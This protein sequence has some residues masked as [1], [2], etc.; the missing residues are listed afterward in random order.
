MTS[1]IQ[2]PPAFHLLA[3]P[4]GATCNLDCAYCFFLSKEMLYPGS[5]FRMADAMLE[6]YIQQLLEAHQTPQ[7]QVA[8]QGGEPTLMGL[9]FFQR[10]IEL[11]ERY[12]KPGTTV[13]YTIQTNGTLLD[14]DWAAFFKQHNFL[15]GISIDGPRAMHDA[16]RVD[17]GGQPTFD[18]VIRGL[19][20]LQKHGVETNTLTTLHHA[21]ADHPAEV[22][23]F[24]RDEC[25]SRFQQYIPIIERVSEVDVERVETPLRSAQHAPGAMSTAPWT[26][27]R[28]RPLYTQ[29]GELVTNRSVTAEQ[30]GRFLIG[31]FEEWVRRDVGAV[32]VQMFDVALANWVGEPSGLCVHSQ[33]C[34]LALALEH[35]GDLF[36]CDHFVE[37]AY[38][39]G[40]ITE[41]LMIELIASPQQQQFGQDKFDA[42]P[43]YCRECEVRFACHGGC[44]K[45]RFIFTPDGEPGLNYLCAGYKLFFHH[46]DQPMRV[47]AEALRRNRA[48]AEI[49]QRYAAQDR[50]LQELFART[51]RNDPCPCGSGKKFKQCHGR[52][53]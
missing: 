30:Y 31:V 21:N 25:G 2:N 37:P 23:R 36:S 50:R 33:T 19:G 26:S 53:A 43:R 47:M 32:Y 49:M 44:P 9:D 46:I 35:N 4:T 52:Q 12:R 13:E 38:R 7:V 29:T 20:F 3:K 17:K 10:S 5:R 16:Y 15:V 41:T 34:G 45:D 39:L 8:W 6:R 42:L 11:V 28:D 27:W 48:P 1:P 24:L 14:D 22:Y 18:K 51:S 40:N